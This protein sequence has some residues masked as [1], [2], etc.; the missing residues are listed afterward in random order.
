MNTVITKLADWGCDIECIKTRFLGDEDFYLSLLPLAVNEENVDNLVAAI[1]RGDASAAFECAHALKGAMGNMGLTPLFN[2]ASEIT[3]L[4]R[5]RQM[6]DVSRL[7]TRLLTARD[8]L[9]K[10]LAQ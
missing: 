6:C 2:P 4:L 3:E 10:I 1:N 8:E 5:D 9:K 7:I